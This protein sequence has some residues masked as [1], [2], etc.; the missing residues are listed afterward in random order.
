M[1]PPTGVPCPSSPTPGTGSLPYACFWGFLLLC[2][3]MML[4]FSSPNLYTLHLC[5]R[6]LLEVSFIPKLWNHKWKFTLPA[7]LIHTIKQLRGFYY[8]QLHPTFPKLPLYGEC[9]YASYNKPTL[10]INAHLRCIWHF[11]TAWTENLGMM[12]QCSNCKRNTLLFLLLIRNKTQVRP[13][14][15]LI[16]Y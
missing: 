5:R 15:R 11:G 9:F 8:L 6:M 3:S 10:N 13:Y 7:T 12:L 4:P 14:C 2:I 16:S 1:C